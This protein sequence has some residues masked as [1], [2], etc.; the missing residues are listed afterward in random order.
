MATRIKLRNDTAE[1]WTA[2]DPVLA[3]G[4]I[5]LEQTGSVWRAKIGNGISRW[6]VLPYSLEPA[7]GGGAAT[8]AEL[9]D[10]TTADLPAINGPLASALAA[11]ASLAGNNTFTGQQEF[12]DT[13]TFLYTAASRANHL[14]SLG[15]G[16]TGAE[17]FGAATVDAARSALQ[18]RVFV[19]PS[20]TTKNNNGV[21]AD[22]PYFTNIP[23]EA[24]VYRI[25]VELMLTTNTTA[26]GTV[27]LSHPANSRPANYISNIFFGSAASSVTQAA[28]GATTTFG[29][30]NV[31]GTRAMHGYLDF[32]FGASGTLSV[33]WAQ[34]TATAVD[35][36]LRAGSYLIIEKL[37]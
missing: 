14:S 24:G 21:I 19:K 22:D 3:K 35:T 32:T 31:N 6:S 27:R 28:T 7:G 37:D 8:F 17:L 34:T 12:S 2:A 9:T 15:A 29:A 23:V 4:E 20:D 30:Y 26:Q 13:S 33:D 5:G 10:K 36:I 25:Y 18:R 11:K 1:N 16:T